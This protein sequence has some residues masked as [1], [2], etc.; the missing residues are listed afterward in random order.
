MAFLLPTPETK[1]FK[2]ICEAFFY[3]KT[4]QNSFRHPGLVF[5]QNN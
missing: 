1:K 3:L 2:I 5:A 4:K